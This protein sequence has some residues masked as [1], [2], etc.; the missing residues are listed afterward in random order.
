M[1][2]LA[3]SIVALAFVSLPALAFAQTPYPDPYLYPSPPWCP[4]CYIAASI[5]Y[6]SST[7]NPALAHDKAA[8]V[9]L[10]NWYIAGW[11]FVCQG[12]ALP[13][14]IEL[15][16]RADDGQVVWLHDTYLV[17]GLFRPDVQ[18]AFSGGCP[19]TP[20]NAGF[21]VY[22]GSTEVP[23]GTR[24]FYVNIWHDGLLHSRHLV[25]TVE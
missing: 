3:R 13:N 9:Q 8:R 24:D 7:S 1:K 21:H 6:P 23:T 17:N 20:S 5:D 2:H 19:G 14:R 22:F 12:G 15:A 16:Y 4:T 18:S 25:I 11:A 10:Q